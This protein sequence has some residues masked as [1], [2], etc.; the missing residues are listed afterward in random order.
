M[1]EKN[2]NKKFRW[3]GVF[4]SV[5][6]WILFPYKKHLMNKALKLS[7]AFSVKVVYCL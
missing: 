5:Q 4:F 1:N 7:A 3:N 6:R 2:S